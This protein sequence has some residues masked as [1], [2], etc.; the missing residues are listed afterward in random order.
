MDASRQRELGE[1]VR[2]GAR[3]LPS[4]LGYRQVDDAAETAVT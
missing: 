4:R 2:G 1:L 3:E